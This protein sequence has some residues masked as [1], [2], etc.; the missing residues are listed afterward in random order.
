MSRTRTL[1]ELRGDVRKKADVEGALARHPDTDLTRYINQ[2]AAAFRDLLV[3][4]RG[5]LSLRAAPV[6]I[7]TV[8]GTSLYAVP[9]ELLQLLSVRHKSTGEQL[10][11]FTTEDETGLRS[12]GGSRGPRYQL[13]G[14][15]LELLPT[16]SAGTVYV[17]DFVSAHMDLVADGDTFEGY[18]GWE[19]YV[20]SW[21]AR[22]IATRDDEPGLYALCSQEMAEVATRIR[23][24]APHRDAARPERVRNAR[25]RHSLRN[26][27]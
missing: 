4:S 15:N 14:A 9:G 19:D 2:G 3:E 22:T 24:H 21:A 8:D 26:R 25:N 18:N 20:V 6:E 12:S 17:V 16:P 1:L 5:R 10:R 27:S 11:D 23:K 7:T 13:Q